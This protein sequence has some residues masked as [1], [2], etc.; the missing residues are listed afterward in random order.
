MYSFLIRRRCDVTMTSVALVTATMI[1]ASLES[2]TNC[3]PKHQRPILI[4]RL[5][6]LPFW[7]NFQDPLS[8]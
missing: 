1:T 6:N 5:A 2:V 4:M 3:R 7:I 8:L